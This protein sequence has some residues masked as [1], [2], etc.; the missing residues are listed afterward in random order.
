M[1]ISTIPRKTEKSHSLPLIL[2]YVKTFNPSFVTVL[3]RV[4]PLGYSEW[5]D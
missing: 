4:K 2:S 1:K 5:I 3:Q